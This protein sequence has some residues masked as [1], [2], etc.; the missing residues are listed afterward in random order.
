MKF[1]IFFSL[2]VFFINCLHHLPASVILMK[3]LHVYSAECNFH[4]VYYD[5]LCYCYT[6]YIGDLCSQK[7]KFLFIHSIFS[8]I[9]IKVTPG[10]YNTDDKC[11]DLLSRVDHLLNISPDK[12]ELDDDE[13]PRLTGNSIGEEKILFGAK[14]TSWISNNLF[15]NIF[16][17]I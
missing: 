12:Y 5:N 9:I 1:I 2:F 17:S 4:G 8:C 15:K 10:Y 13:F 11:D 14:S 16:F 7:S 3:K 6:D